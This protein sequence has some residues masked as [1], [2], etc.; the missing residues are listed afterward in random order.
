VLSVVEFLLPRSSELE[1]PFG[2]GRHAI[3]A[4]QVTGGALHSRVRSAL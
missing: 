1:D 4:A 3:P 2:A